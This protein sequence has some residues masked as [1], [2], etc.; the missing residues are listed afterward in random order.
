[1]QEPFFL[2]DI[3]W[4]R[5]QSLKSVPE[6]LT[7][8]SGS[9]NEKY[10]QTFPEEKNKGFQLRPVPWIL[11]TGQK[12]ITETVCLKYGSDFS[13]P[14]ISFFHLPLPDFE[15]QHCCLP[16]T[17]QRP[18]FLSDMLSVWK[19]EEGNGNN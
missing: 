5:S 7:V 10:L 8:L 9:L 6:E 14:T 16:E 18:T 15:I 17:H 19:K 4:L 12:C 2:K 13:H 3:P 11:E 1:M